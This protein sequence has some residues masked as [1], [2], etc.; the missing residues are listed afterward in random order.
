MNVSNG[1]K[2][3]MIM[4]ASWAFA[5]LFL[6]ILL[7]IVI[8]LTATDTPNSST[9][10]ITGVFSSGDS[11]Q[12]N[13]ETNGSPS[14]VLLT[15]EGVITAKTAKQIVDAYNNLSEDDDVVGVILNVNSPGGGV[16]A[17]E[18]IRIAGEKF[19][20]NKPLYASVYEIGASGGYM[21]SLPASKIYAYPTSLVGSVGV[22]SESLEATELLERLGLNYTIVKTGQYKATGNIAHKLTQSEL[23]NSQE[24]IDSLFAEFV[25]NVAIGRNMTTEEVLALAEGQVFTGTQGI[26]NGLVDELGD[27]DDAFET[28][29]M[30]LN[31]TDEEKEDVS[32]VEYTIPTQGLGRSLLG[33]ASSVAG[34]AEEFSSAFTSSAS[35]SAPEFLAP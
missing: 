35:S 17:S 34:I 1:K 2:T 31:L 19:A 23:D 14:I 8:A 13:Y 3:S 27:Y 6:F 4:I 32:L 28:M 11:V 30:S 33:A 9:N 29:K 5:I 12:K 24:L 7:K 20:K 10:L 15:L 21:S 16:S 26:E 25:K 18:R 22:I